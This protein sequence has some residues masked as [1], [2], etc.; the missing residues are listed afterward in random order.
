MVRHS[1]SSKAQWPVTAT[2]FATAA[3][4]SAYSRTTRQIQLRLPAHWPSG[5]FL[6][7]LATGMVDRYFGVDAGENTTFGTGD[8][9]GAA[10]F[11]G[12]VG[13]IQGAVTTGSDAVPSF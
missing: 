1:S 3:L 5:G 13:K 2:I 4:S 11:L 6:T 12:G 10:A 9:N 7:W 8:N